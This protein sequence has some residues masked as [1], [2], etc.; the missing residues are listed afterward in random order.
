VVVCAKCGRGSPDDFGFCPFCGASL[1]AAQPR[2]VRKFVS[3]LFCDLT[4]STALGDRIDPEALRGVMRQYYDNARMVLERHGGTVEKFVGDA[5][6]AVFGIPVATE[7]DALRAVRAAVELRDAVQDLGL[8]AR[9]GVNTGEVVAIEGDA[10][11]IGDAVNVAARLEQSAVPGNVLLGKTTANLVRDAVTTEPLEL[12]LR[13]KPKPVTAYRLMTLDAAATGVARHLDRPM[14]GR[15][16]ELDRLAADFSDAAAAR[17]SRLFTLI[18]PAGVGKSRLVADF[19]T[20]VGGTATVA[21][22]RALSYGDGITYWPLVEI[23]VQLGIEPDRAISSSPADTQLAVRALFAE[24]AR[25]RPLIVVID[26]L[27]WAEPPMLDLIEHIADWSR[28][29]PILLLCIARPELLDRRPGWGGG[30]LNAT[31]VLLEPLV[32]AEAEQFADLLL[33]GLSLDAETRRHILAIAEGNPL[34]LEEMAALAREA[35]GAVR[36]PPTIRA[37]LQARLDLLNG[38]ER[39]VIERGAVEG[40]V[41]HR[42]S[43]TALA[44]PAERDGLPHQLVALVRKELIRPDHSQITGDD[45]YRFRHLLI[46]DTAY[47]ALPKEVRAEL[48]ERFADWVESV[49]ALLEQDEIVG[50]HLERAVHYLR[51]LGS[52][53]SRAARLSTRAGS[54][55]SAAGVA[56]Y[57]RGDV[58][59]VCN[60]LGRAVAVLPPGSQRR[61]VI[62]DLVEALYQ[63]GRPA[64]TGVLIQEL[65]G[66]DEADRATAVVLRVL[67][68]PISPTS[69]IER[70]RDA[71]ESA[72]HR[73]DASDPVSVLRYERARAEFAWFTC[74]AVETHHAVLRAYQIAKSL[75]RRDLF[76]DLILLLIGSAWFSGVRAS[77]TLG[78]MDDIED[79]FGDKAGPLLSASLQDARGFTEYLAGLISAEE[80]RAHSHRYIEMLQQTGSRME[81]MHVLDELSFVAWVD[82][83][84]AV[85]EQ[86]KERII[87]EYERIGD[88]NYLVNMLGETALNKSRLGRPEEALEMVA[89]ARRVGSQEDIADQI[90]L[91][92]AEA[93]ARARHGDQA[94]AR[95]SLESARIRAAGTRMK[96]L[97][98]DI[99][100]VEGEIEMMAGN[101]ARAMEIADRLETQSRELGLP[102]YAEALRRT[103]VSASGD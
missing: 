41:F 31:S 12:S 40:K 90:Q 47:D 35:D 14:V 21:R 18:G 8:E 29:V 22:G 67:V 55:L 94:S 63:G 98:D 54:R 70:T 32:S 83:D 82:G 60:L 39:T 44:P 74:D 85:R 48:H 27:Q 78:L 95:S 9:I 46:R 87:E 28:D 57:E 66:G 96:I 86:I 75:G 49:P 36:V 7:D 37:L 24:A 58:Y 50:Y 81:A 13:G 80:K 69:S 93:H 65:E 103:V 77:E 64:D 101:R 34:F 42:G 15:K 68:E 17:T 102:R 5:V 97:N 76:R 72:A 61:H 84:L 3:V 11:V 1:Q 73:V 33:A 16:R 79:W 26:D 53:D 51:E 56:A 2:Q 92:L 45:A 19:L 100:V 25:D 23:L 20:R 59:A 71:L 89:N 38:T 43:V 4:G 91:D 52:D 10:L 62:P 88:R 30:K 6:M 99:D